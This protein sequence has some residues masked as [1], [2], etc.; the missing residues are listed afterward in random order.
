MNHPSSASFPP[1]PPFSI[2]YLGYPIIP[3]Q[4]ATCAQV[5]AFQISSGETQTQMSCFYGLLAQEVWVQMRK[6]NKTNK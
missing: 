6:Q 2:S 5:L 1:L 3:L 4:I